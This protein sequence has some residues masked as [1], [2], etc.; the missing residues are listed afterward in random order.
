VQRLAGVINCRV[1]MTEARGG[2][3][4]FELPYERSSWTCPFDELVIERPAVV[5]RMIGA[6]HPVIF[7][8]G[9]Y[10]LGRC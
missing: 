10:R 4:D 3:R 2:V 7:D 6:S 1:Y 9:Q 5:F 8:N